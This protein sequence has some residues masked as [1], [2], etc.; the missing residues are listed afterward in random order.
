MR[1]LTLILF[2]F[3]YST[4]HA[5]QFMYEIGRVNATFIYSNSDNESLDNLYSETDF[6]YAF[7]YRMTLSKSFYLRIGLVYNG[8]NNRGT[9]PVH[10]NIYEWKTSYAGLQVSPEY[11]F[12]NGKKFKMLVIGSIEPQ[13]FL[14]GTQI[15]N[16]Q[17][18]DLKGIEQFDRP[19][20]FWKGGVSA[21]YCLDKN[22]ALSVRYMLGQGNPLGESSDSEILKLKTSTFS[23][24][25]L[26]G[27]KNC[28]YCQN[29][30]L[31]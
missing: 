4:I 15:I 24:G 11:Q 27:I 30:R 13:F 14:K 21:N 18:Y 9:D 16:R 2:L 20:L 25:L 8:Y 29:Q 7:G 12:L 19:F 17:I 26:W 3:L 10:D 31:R 23:V 22:V 5:Q 28:K 1:Y 6:S